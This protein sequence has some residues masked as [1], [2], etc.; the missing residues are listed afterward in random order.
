MQLVRLMGLYLPALSFDLPFFRMGIRT[1]LFHIPGKVPVFQLVLKIPSSFLLAWGPRLIRRSF[2]TLSVPGAFFVFSSF[3]LASS[4][5][6][7]MGAVIT[8]SS[9][10]L[11]L[12]R[13]FCC[14]FFTAFL[15]ALLIG[16]FDISENSFIRWFAAFFPVSTLSSIAIDRGEFLFGSPLR[17]F[18]RFHNF[19]PLFSKS[20]LAVFSCQAFLIAAIVSLLYFAGAAFK[21]MLFSTVGSISVLFLAA[22]TSSCSSFSS[23]DQ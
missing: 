11:K 14:I 2:G 21:A 7:V 8:S 19:L 4:S 13:C 10:S 22:D 6:I 1:A 16:M 23:S 5:S 3:R 12:S 15:C 17:D 9:G 18:V 20:K